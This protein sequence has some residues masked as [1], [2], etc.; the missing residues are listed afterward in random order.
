MPGPVGR[1]LERR[2]ASGDLSN[3]VD[4][5]LSPDA[6]EALAK[7]ANFREPNIMLLF[8]NVCMSIFLCIPA[9]I[10]GVEA[11]YRNIDD[12]K[13]NAAYM[14]SVSNDPYLLTPHPPPCG[15]PVPDM[16]DILK[17]LDRENGW[18]GVYQ[19][20]WSDYNTWNATIHHGICGVNFAN[21]PDN[22]DGIKQSGE[23]Y[24]PTVGE[25]N[26][27]YT[28]GAELSAI[29][30]IMK[31][32]GLYL[33]NDPNDFYATHYNKMN[34]EFCDHS[35]NA[36]YDKRERRIYGELKERI[37]K[38]YVTAAPA[39]WRYQSYLTSG[40]NSNDAGIKGWDGNDIQPSELGCLEGM[41]P[42]QYCANKD[43]IEEVMASAGS[44]GA[45]ARMV[46]ANPTPLPHFTEMLYALLALSNVGIIDRERNQGK[47]FGNIPNLDGDDPSQ[48]PHN[49]LRFC[50]K[51]LGS[52][53][54]GHL[55]SYSLDPTVE[56]T[57]A[58]TTPGAAKYL[59]GH[60]ALYYQKG[61]E[62]AQDAVSCNDGSSPPPPAP[63]TDRVWDEPLNGDTY[64]A[65]QGAC[66][67]TLQFGLFDLQR[68]FGIP[69]VEDVFVVDARPHSG[70][71][72]GGELI[73]K[74]LFE[75]LMGASVYQNPAARL[76]AY[77]AYRVA[78]TTVLG[79]L[80]SSCLGFFGMRG[81]LPL[82]VQILSLCGLAK[83]RKGTSVV[84]TRPK[85]EIP[86]LLASFASMLLFAYIF[87]LDPAVQSNY[88]ITHECD[89]WAGK[90]AW[91][92]A[93][94]FVTTWYSKRWGVGRHG[95]QILGIIML[96][97]GIL[98]FLYSMAAVFFLY[99][100]RKKASKQ[101]NQWTK[102]TIAGFFVLFITVGISLGLFA[103]IAQR[104]GM[105]YHTVASAGGDTTRE[106]RR[107]GND[108]IAAVYASF[109]LSA[110]VGHSRARWALDALT[111]TYKA[112]WILGGVL[113]AVIPIIQTPILV[114]R[115]LWEG[116]T[117]DGQ[118][119]SSE[120]TTMV[121]FLYVAMALQLGTFGFI[122]FGFY[123]NTLED[124]NIV[125]MNT[126]QEVQKE[127]AKEI[128]AEMESDDVA[129]NL[130][131]AASEAPYARPEIQKLMQMN[132]A[133]PQQKVPLNLMTGASAGW[134]PRDARGRYLPMIKVRH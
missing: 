31:R 63:N 119:V 36:W 97:L 83:N 16:V 45:L 133:V 54:W 57:N 132:I 68:L 84:L 100:L 2:N 124:A 34:T 46:G 117:S 102:R 53:L 72:I 105:E 106:A 104:S 61:M 30:K 24:P 13:H 55:Q 49:A 50:E 122:A 48:R 43:H 18:G 8:R 111:K 33:I 103:G 94:P 67:N 96:F 26:S 85:L 70:F 121:V 58:D 35:D 75:D 120:R 129:E 98:P 114:G 51:V 115:D 14:H 134:Q 73:Y 81:L 4:E 80:T 42:F 29:A 125:A 62:K 128:V 71:E 101:K 23:Q 19:I 78:S 91:S 127:A 77:L 95:V 21:W 60:A 20:V 74:P 89:H 9:F 44:A 69:D 56:Q 79:M 10:L 93:G 66:A 5:A 38:A 12:F 76:E 131:E 88:Y 15:L 130:I 17:A 107:L 6:V 25:E 27:R 37:A 123:Q 22:T 28:I 82:T 99:K 109:W 59:D 47:C 126:K 112:I 86:A 90:D 7:W 113:F 11:L 108:C 1:S 64:N 3:Q 32:D 87:W 118:P 110:L 41:N 40:Q 39:F 116:K 52:D 92:P 65:V